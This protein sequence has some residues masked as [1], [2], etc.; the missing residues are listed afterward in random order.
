VKLSIVI[1]TYRREQVLV[2]TVTQLLPLITSLDQ[3]TELLIIDQ[4]EQ[5]HETTEKFLID[6]CKSGLLHWLRLPNPHLTAAMNIGLLRARG[7]IVLYL[8][9]D[10]IPHSDLLH[11]HIRAHS[12]HDE[13]LVVVGQVLQPGQNTLVFKSDKSRSTLWR[14]LDFRFNSVDS[15]WIE[16]AI[17][18]NMSLKRA[19]CIALGGFDE[20]FPPPVA[21]RFETEFAKRLIRSGGKV[22]FAPTASIHHLAAGSGGT[23][24]RGSHLTSASP[25][26]G[27]GDFYYA[28]RCGSGFDLTWYLLRKPMREVRTK[29]HLR[30]PWWIPV[31]LIGE[32][33]AL[34]NALKLASRPPRLIDKH[35]HPS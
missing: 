1:P 12:E 17:A 10:I 31:K 25:L 23:R 7:E 33:R 9:D 30:H 28:L 20:S 29:F 16:N 32:F 27:V 8:D 11:A 3:P 35:S 34:A 2:D 15:C 21:A 18:C 26:Y 22:L 14:D 4:T 6:S 19:S 13:A 24:S 5:H